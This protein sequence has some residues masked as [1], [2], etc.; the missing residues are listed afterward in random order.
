MVSFISERLLACLKILLACNHNWLVQRRRLR[1]P[2][3]LAKP[4]RNKIFIK[5]NIVFLYIVKKYDYL[6]FISSNIEQFIIFNIKF[7]KYLLKVH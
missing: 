2:S 1:Q 7:I 3:R 4:F 6:E 5:K